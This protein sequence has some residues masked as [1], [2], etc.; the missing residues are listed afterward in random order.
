M[1]AA[2]NFLAW[3]LCRN[4][5]A[6]YSRKY[7]SPLGILWPH[8]EHKW[9]TLAL[10][11]FKTF[12]ESNFDTHTPFVWS[13]TIRSYR[14]RVVSQLCGAQCDDSYFPSLRASAAIKLQATRLGSTRMSLTRVRSSPNPAYASYSQKTS[15]QMLLPHEGDPDYLLQ[16]QRRQRPSV[17]FSKHLWQR[18][19]T[20]RV[21][22][23]LSSP[24]PEARPAANV[25]NRIYPCPKTNLRFWTCRFGLHDQGRALGRIDPGPDTVQQLRSAYLQCGGLPCIR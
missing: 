25:H 17:R 19:V 21:S 2:Q 3:R 5:S 15:G 24:K 16:V 20:D 22:L 4:L 6:R 12:K 14:I 7:I 18:N 1:Q 11:C 9:S 8:Q 10:V 23:G 13:M